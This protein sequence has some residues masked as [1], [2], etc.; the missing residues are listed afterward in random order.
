MEGRVFLDRFYKRYRGRDPDEALALL[1]SRTRPVPH[2]LATVFRSVRPDADYAEFR[3]FM[4]SGCRT[5]ISTKAT[6]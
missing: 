2:R 3:A 5:P 6:C 1:A 4:K